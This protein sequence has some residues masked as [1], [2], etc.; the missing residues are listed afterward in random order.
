[1]LLLSCR[2]LRRLPTLFRRLT[3]L[4]IRVGGL[5]LDH[6]PPAGNQG[7]IFRW[8]LPST[9]RC[10]QCFAVWDEHFRLPCRNQ[11]RQALAGTSARR[12]SDIFQRLILV[13][14]AIS[15]ERPSVV[16]RVLNRRDHFFFRRSFNLA[17][18]LRP[19]ASTGCP[20]ADLMKK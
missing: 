13:L 4:K 16:F 19:F 3:V 15:E 20:I 10:I 12:E 9:C 5:L 18:A 6:G 1:M 2:I 8:N 17:F 11:S 14:M 7:L